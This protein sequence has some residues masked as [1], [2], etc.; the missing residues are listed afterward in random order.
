MFLRTL[1][2]KSVVWKFAVEKA[3]MMAVVWT[4]ESPA[5]VR[6]HTL[7]AAEAVEMQRPSLQL[8]TMFEAVL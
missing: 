4:R 7:T 1:S 6:A 2:E 8:P 3:L 5:Q